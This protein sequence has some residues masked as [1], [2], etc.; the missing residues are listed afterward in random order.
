MV[1]PLKKVEGEVQPIH[2]EVDSLGR[3]WPGPAGSKTVVVVFVVMSTSEFG[4]P[5]S[6]PCA[7]PASESTDCLRVGCVD[8]EVDGARWV[9]LYTR[10]Y[11]LKL[12]ENEHVT[13]SSFQASPSVRH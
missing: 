9:G 5:L 8:E 12:T 6:T 4:G 10:M 13:F 1:V 2:H 11:K 3:T 7:A